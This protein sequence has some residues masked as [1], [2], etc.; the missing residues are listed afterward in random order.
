MTSVNWDMSRLTAKVIYEAVFLPRV[1][2]VA[3]V[4]SEGFRLKKSIKVLCSIQRVPLLAITSAYRTASTNC[5]SVVAG[6]LPLDLEVRR[7]AMKCR[8]RKG[9]VT[10][11]EYENGLARLIEE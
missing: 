10:N 6:V 3:E 7:L 4:W 1:T 8:L 11:Q 5:Q 2:Y 9:E